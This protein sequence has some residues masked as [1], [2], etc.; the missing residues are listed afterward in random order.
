M[1]ARKRFTTVRKIAN[2]QKRNYERVLRDCGKDLRESNVMTD[3]LARVK[4]VKK[5]AKIGKLKGIMDWCDNAIY[6]INTYSGTSHEAEVKADIERM[7][8]KIE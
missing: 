2:D 5:I 1:R 6:M 3:L 4:E 7:L 8:S